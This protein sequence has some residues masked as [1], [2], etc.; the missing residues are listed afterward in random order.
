MTHP[1]HISSSP[2]TQPALFIPHGA[3]PCFFMDWNP[4][5]TWDGM[6]QYLRSIGQ[7]LP[8]RPTAIL[9][10][11]A[12]WRTTDFCVTS[13]PEPELIYDYYGF[14]ES[15]YQLTYP[16]QGSPALAA[17]VQTLLSNAAIPCQQDNN[18]GL[19]HGTFIPLK[20]MF[21][22]AD[23][24][25][26]QLS[27]R[28]DLD[29]SA[30]IAAGKALA[31]LRDEGILIIGSG[32]SFHNMRG[33]G[34]ARFTAPSQ[35]FDQWLTQTVQAHPEQR[36][37]ALCTW[38]IAPAAHLCHPSG[39]E[40]HLIPLMLIAGSAANDIGHKTYSEVVLKTQLSAFQFS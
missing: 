29:P 20:L 7:S 13:H 8:A 9:M 24:P 26:V 19:D 31:P 16:A 11:S 22:E 40:E 3:G 39:Q 14:P 2:L 30:H 5:N 28:Q 33:Y 34:D 37:E 38:S 17:R 23:I 15:T 25:V 35:T 18:R 10:V 4:A 27:L 32:M 36:N 21:P 6:S 1:Q 12:H